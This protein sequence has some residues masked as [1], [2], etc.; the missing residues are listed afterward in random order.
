ME[1]RD[2]ETLD[3][4]GKTDQID[5]WGGEGWTGGMDNRVGAKR[6]EETKWVGIKRSDG[7]LGDRMQR[8]RKER[9]NAKC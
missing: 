1:K 9:K 8:D 2:A 6:N 7:V 3:K 4:E 5:S